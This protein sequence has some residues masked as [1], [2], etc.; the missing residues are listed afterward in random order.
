M[1]IQTKTKLVFKDA[2]EQQNSENPM[3]ERLC[4]QVAE[5]HQVAAETVFAA[6]KLEVRE[7][8]GFAF[9]P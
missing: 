7:D 2:E 1:N 5:T 9:V 3:Q 6:R 8:A 4:N